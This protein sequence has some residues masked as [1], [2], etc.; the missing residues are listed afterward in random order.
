M[1][2]HGYGRVGLKT[3]SFWLIQIMPD[4]ALLLSTASSPEIW[5]VTIQHISSP[6]LAIPIPSLMMEEFH[7]KQYFLHDLRSQHAANYRNK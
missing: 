2:T 7:R 6:W 3:Q 1:K 4:H 5:G